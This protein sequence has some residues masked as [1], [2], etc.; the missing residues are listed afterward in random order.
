MKGIMSTTH[1]DKQ[2]GRMTKEAMLS[3]IEQTNK[4]YVPMGIEHDPRIPPI[5]RIEFTELIELE[6]GEY[7]IQGTFHIFE[8]GDQLTY[9]KNDRRVSIHD[10]ENTKIHLCHD[11]ILSDKKTK[12]LIESLSQILGSEPQLEV[13][14]SL[15]PISI[16]TIVG[17]FILGG[18]FSGF[19]NKLGSDLYDKLIETLKVYFSRI[20]EKENLLIIRS[21]SK[22]R[23]QLIEIEIIITNPD[24]SKISRFFEFDIKELDSQLIKLESKLNNISKLEM[25]HKRYMI[26]LLR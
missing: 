3:L 12:E 10:D 5:G 22:V 13:K 25:K 7:G 20:K 8:K 19:F 16:L 21:I 11:Q 18:I 9:K 15:E 26:K 17:A 6:D 1:I 23:D 2:G 14:K 4:Y 24:D